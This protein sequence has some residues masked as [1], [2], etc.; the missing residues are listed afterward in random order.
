MSLGQLKSDTDS[1]T[2]KLVLDGKIPQEVSVPKIT[3]NWVAP[4]VY[5]SDWT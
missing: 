5:M 2:P 3:A 1:F 4:G